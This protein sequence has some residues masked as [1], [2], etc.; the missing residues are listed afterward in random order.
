MK[1]SWR[2]SQRRMNETNALLSGTNTKWH[3]I[4]L[5]LRL[6]LTVR[7]VYAIKMKLKGGGIILKQGRK[8]YVTLR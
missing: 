7:K 4:A 3:S 1:Y 6:E 2:I 8:L 5:S